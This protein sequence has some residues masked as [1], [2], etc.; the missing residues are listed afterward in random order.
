VEFS[1]ADGFHFASLWEIR[2]TTN[3]TYDI[4]RGRVTEDSGYGP[5]IRQR[6]WV[7]VGDT[8]PNCDVW[9]SSANGEQDPPAGRLGS[10]GELVPE[11][12]F[13]FPGDPPPPPPPPDA[14]GW[15]F[16]LHPCWVAIPVWC[17]S[18]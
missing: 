17:V 4:D 18:E 2:D 9:T 10:V 1:C 8:V 14:D 7:R 5:P 15:A 13:A 12:L 16:G 3:L 6:G 11:E